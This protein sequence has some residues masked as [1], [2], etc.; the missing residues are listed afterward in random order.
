MLR[1]TDKSFRYVPSF[2]TD[3]G[4]R[5]KEIIEQQRLLAAKTARSVVALAPKLVGK[6]AG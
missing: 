4:K 5:F 3:L 6:R 2:A 1:I